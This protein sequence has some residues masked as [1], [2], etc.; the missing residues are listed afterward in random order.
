M[1]MLMTMLRS[2]LTTMLTTMTRGSR[3]RILCAVGAALV[4]ALTVS[5]CTSGDGGA[6]RGDANAAAEQPSELPD[7]ASCPAA[8]GQPATGERALSEVVL[9]CLDGSGGEL[10]VGEAPGV[11][12]VVNL[13]A[14]WCTPCRDELPLFEQL[15]EAADPAALRVIGVASRDSAS[16]AADLAQDLGLSFPN[17]FDDNGDVMIAGVIRNLPGTLFLDADG[18]VAFIKADAVISS[19]AEL[20]ALVQEHLG[21]IL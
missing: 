8:T 4:V 7:L 10:T 18:G 12:T 20:V 9:P 2:T 13:W 1:T 11:P 15:Y 21:V 6:A 19:Y 5:A 16:F 14:S 3:A 17:G